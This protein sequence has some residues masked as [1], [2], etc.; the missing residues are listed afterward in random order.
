M[1]KIA[2]FLLVIVAS[3]PAWSQVNLLRRAVGL[4]WTICI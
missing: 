1:L 4:D 3:A 2:C